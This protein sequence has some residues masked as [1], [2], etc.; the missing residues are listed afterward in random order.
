MID[1]SVRGREMRRLF[2]VL[3]TLALTAVVSCEGCSGKGGGSGGGSGGG[4]AGW[5]VGRDSLMMNV[6]DI[7]DKIGRYPLEGKGDLLA[8]AC[9]GRSRAWVVGDRGLLITTEDAG[10][11]WRTVALGIESRLVAV[12]IA[13]KGRVYVAGDGGVFRVSTDA[14]ATWTAVPSPAV[15]W[16]SVAA[17]HDGG[18]VLLTTA[19][20]DIYR[21][22]GK[23]LT[24]V[25]SAPAAL[26]SIALSSDGLTA[27]AVGDA[28]TML[29]STDGG[30]RW[31]DRPSGTTRALRD[32]WLIGADGNA[33][34]AVGDG[35]VLITGL[36][37][38]NDGVAPRSLGALTLR[39]LHLEASG[40]GAIV[41][42][43]GALFL[44]RDFGT[45]WKRLETGELRDIFGVDA[46]GDDHEHL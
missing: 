24:A 29:L 37:A 20:G 1:R 36:T 14:G 45:S 2:S 5:L 12:A 39:G 31:R 43:G 22:D 27:V 8:I 15:D 10:A 25:T 46:L 21:Y 3:G 16:T 41:G 40:R 42:D 4:T 28:G 30:Q 32:V 38:G 33:V 18:L 6:S 34:F 7:D 11:S 9:W 19:G 13:E 23:A 17:R 35:G 44:T 26:R